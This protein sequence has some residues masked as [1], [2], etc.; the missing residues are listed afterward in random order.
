MR[1]LKLRPLVRGLTARDP[2]HFLAIS[3][4]TAKHDA[5]GFSEGISKSAGTR[6]TSGFISKLK[7]LA[8]NKPNRFKQYNLDDGSYDLSVLK[9][10]LRIKEISKGQR[11]PPHILVL[12][13]A[14]AVA[15]FCR[16]DE[17]HDGES[18]EEV[19]DRNDCW[20]V[21][22]ERI[23]NK[24]QP[25]YKR[26]RN[27][28]DG[29]H[30]GDYPK[31]LTEDSTKDSSKDFTNI[32]RVGDGTVKAYA[33][34]PSP[35]ILTEKCYDFYNAKKSYQHS[36]CHHP[37]ICEKNDNYRGLISDGY[38]MSAEEKYEKWSQEYRELES[39][40]MRGEITADEVI[41]GVRKTIIENLSVSKQNSKS[42]R[43]GIKCISHCCI[44]PS[45]IVLLN[46]TFNTDCTQDT[47]EIEDGIHVKTS[48]PIYPEGTQ[49]QG[50][51]I[52]LPSAT[53]KKSF[54]FPRR[55]M[56]INLSPLR[57]LVESFWNLFK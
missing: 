49:F 50:R 57:R 4:K 11:C 55:E 54:P 45:H 38:A 22:L 34:S 51:H 10:I 43:T 16:K 48:T 39:R 17:I 9:E 56:D 29:I 27:V 47:F 1:D 19:D 23:L 36:V 3:Q 21:E 24:S 41:R 14:F 26:L 13:D 5:R 32:E 8:D 42:A 2:F 40:M 6:T 20:V 28:M 30:N 25:L 44:R 15:T 46:A 31:D 53:E 12:C 37:Y 18:Y 35:M 33:H 52:K 7:T